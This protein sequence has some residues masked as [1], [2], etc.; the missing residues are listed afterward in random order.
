MVVDVC[1]REP[2]EGDVVVNVV[3]NRG[4][5]QGNQLTA[6]ADTPLASDRRG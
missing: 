4:A 2:L 1:Q 5:V 3:V 6:A